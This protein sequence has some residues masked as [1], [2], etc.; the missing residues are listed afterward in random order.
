MFKLNKMEF[1]NFANHFN[2]PKKVASLKTELKSEDFGCA[3]QKFMQTHSILLNDFL[4]LKDV[5]ARQHRQI[6]HIHQQLTP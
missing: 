5:K 2:K 6:N 3:E 4:T 1:E